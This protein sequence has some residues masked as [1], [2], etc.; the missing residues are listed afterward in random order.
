M[1][2]CPICGCRNS[3][4]VCRCEI[5]GVAFPKRE[6]PSPIPQPVAV[7]VQTSVVIPQASP[8]DNKSDRMAIAGFVLSL[9]GIVSFITTPLQLAALLLSIAAG[10]TKRFSTLRRTGIILSSIALGISL[11]LWVIVLIYSQ[12]I[13]SY[14]TDIMNE[15]FY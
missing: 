1:K 11:I 5:C 4:N 7:P 15:F 10:K 14:L 6:V 3:D 9:M 12:D 13:F 8:E 2:T